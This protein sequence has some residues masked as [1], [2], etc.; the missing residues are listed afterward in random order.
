MKMKFVGVVALVVLAV[1]LR[2][3]DKTIPLEDVVARNREWAQKYRGADNRLVQDDIEKEW[4][5]DMRRRYAGRRVVA[6]GEFESVTDY[7][8]SKAPDVHGA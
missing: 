6:R 3:A 8:R 2:A 4:W 7:S 5:A 1:P